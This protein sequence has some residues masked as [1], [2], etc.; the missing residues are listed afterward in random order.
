MSEKWIL[1]VCGS[2]GSMPVHG[3]EYREFGGATSCYILKKGSYA[4]VVDCG[5]GFCRA[6]ELLAGCKKVDIWLTHLHYDHLIGIL[7]YG[8]IPG[9]AE[10]HFYG[11]FDRW[12]RTD[13]IKE[14]FREPFWP[15]V[16][17]IG[18][19]VCVKSP[20]EY[21]L[22]EELLVKSYPAP[23]PNEAS[24]LRIE[25][26]ERVLCV[27]F[28]YERTQEPPEGFLEGCSRLAF[29]GMYTEEEYESHRGWGHSCYSDGCAY[30]RQYGIPKLYITHHEPRRT[31]EE[32]RRLE[33][34]AVKLY[35]NTRF[36]RMGDMVEL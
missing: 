5:S 34:E 20:G 12:F 30:A 16:P 25:A 19:C 3:E 1:H 31:D 17:D 27:M 22:R 18:P 15:V 8:V 36:A 14:F 29:D 6:K 32:L 13:T 4:L 28:D 2:R 7:S 24:I 21:R 26:G 11:T 10:V 33:A 23:H 9:E 35:P